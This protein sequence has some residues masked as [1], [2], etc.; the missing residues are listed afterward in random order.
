M[1]TLFHLDLTS[2]CLTLDCPD[3]VRLYHQDAV[4]SF[5]AGFSATKLREMAPDQAKMH[6][7]LLARHGPALLEG[8]PWLHL[9]ELKAAASFMF[10]SGRRLRGLSFALRYLARKP[11]SPDVLAAA[12]SGTLGPTAF[13]FLKWVRSR[14]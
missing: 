13:L 10:L 7:E 11:L 4:N 5:C 2:H 9:A 8:A 3:V 1:E 14:L 12:V 6:E